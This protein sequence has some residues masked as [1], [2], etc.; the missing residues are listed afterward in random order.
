[1]RLSHAL[2]TRL[3]MAALA[4]AV[5]AGSAWAWIHWQSANSIVPPHTYQLQAGNSSDWRP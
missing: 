4:L 3:L 5:L 1:M 2:P